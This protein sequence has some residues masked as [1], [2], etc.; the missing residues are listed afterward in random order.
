M[1]ELGFPFALN[2]KQ[3]ARFHTRQYCTETQWRA[4]FDNKVEK[5]FEDIE[6]ASDVIFVHGIVS[7]LRSS[8]WS[9]IIINKSSNSPSKIHKQNSFISL[10]DYQKLLENSTRNVPIETLNQ[11]E[12]DLPR[13]FPEQVD[14]ANSLRELTSNSETSSKFDGS[15]ASLVSYQNQTS[16]NLRLGEGSIHDATRRILYAF[17]SEFPAVGYLQSMNFIAAFILLVHQR[18]QPLKLKTST[19]RAVKRR[20]LEEIEALGDSSSSTFKLT[21]SHLK[22]RQKRTSV[23]LKSIQTNILQQQSLEKKHEIEIKSYSTL[24]FIVNTCLQGYF[25]PDM[26]SLLIDVH[27]FTKIFQIQLP[28]LFDFFSNLNLMEVPSL[29][30]PKWL[31]CI[32]LNTFP[33]EITLHIWDY[34]LL[35]NENAPRFLLEV[36]LAIFHICQDDIIANVKNFNDLT[37]YLKS[38]HEKIHDSSELIMLTKSPECT[39]EKMSIFDL[40]KFHGGD[41]YE[42]LKSKLPQGELKE[43]IKESTQGGTRKKL[44][45]KS[46]SFFRLQTNPTAQTQ[47]V[48]LK[49]KRDD[50]LPSPFNDRKG[51]SR[52]QSSNSLG[53]SIHL[54]SPI[55]TIDAS[56]G[57]SHTPPCVPID[58]PIQTLASPLF[59]SPLGLKSPLGKSPSKKLKTDANVSSL[60]D[61]SVFASLLNPSIVV[62]S[63]ARSLRASK[64]KQVAAV[65]SSKHD[66]APPL[67]SISS[68]A[69][70]LFQGNKKKQGLE[71]KKSFSKKN[72]SRKS[73]YSTKYL[74]LDPVL[75][76]HIPADIELQPR[77]Q[78]SSI[79]LQLMSPPLRKRR[80]D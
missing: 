36:S 23:N 6:L 26:S 10:K 19:T 46:H 51:L 75:N 27:I 7:T 17:V 77:K 76:D 11:I 22:K 53:S 45:G 52:I 68:L 73:A 47:V 39:L 13:T 1:D 30:L 24:R 34:M 20:V 40:R 71:K 16:I 61:A 48:A 4:K 69:T 72:M 38:I 12:L 3:L 60:K 55:P 57:S 58:L 8:V 31:L 54:S 56:K 66:E 25:S 33:S 21:Q 28:L 5:A 29:F 74:E 15:R 64:V 42:S 18:L 43:S 44:H 14:F 50:T 41:L 2:A 49:R 78:Q 59:K 37:L 62:S 9:N 79:Q 80:P 32:F 35:Q 70:S 63:L 67:T 65:S